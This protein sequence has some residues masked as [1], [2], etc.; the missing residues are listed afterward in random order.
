[1]SK[2]GQAPSVPTIITQN[3]PIV[4]LSTS[5]S[6]SWTQSGPT[7]DNYTVDTTTTVNG[8][9]GVAPILNT[10]ILNGTARMVNITGLE[11]NSAVG[12]TLTAHN[13]AGSTPR[14]FSVPRITLPAGKTKHCF[15]I[16]YCFNP[17]CC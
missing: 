11:E 1:L 4:A 13:A 14:P 16:W 3:P 8:C 15:P 7:V 10:I 17:H 5:V 2:L 12:I 6:F 9:S